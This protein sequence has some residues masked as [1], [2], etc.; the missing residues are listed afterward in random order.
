MMI[1]I[2]FH[3]L[4]N[5]DLEVGAIYE[6]GHHGTL[7]GEPIS[8]V[9]RGCGNQG[10]IRV[11]GQ[12]GA[13]KFVV[14]YSTFSDQDWPDRL[15]SEKAKLVYFGDNKKPGCELHETNAGGNVFFRE[16]F[17]NLHATPNGRASA[18]AIFLFSRH[19]TTAS[20]RSVIFRGLCVPGHPGYSEM[21]DLVAVWKSK[22]GGRYQN[23]RAVFS[24]LNVSVVKRA[25]IKDIQ[26]GNS[27][28]SAAPQAWIN[29]VEQGVYE[30]LASD[31]ANSPTSDGI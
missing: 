19:E 13:R 29:W 26:S 23:Y 31:P 9:L 16:L 20:R 14:L 25:W 2:D 27:K 22:D 10:G 24:V 4:E 3:D 7:A 21:D 30:L 17:W 12:F 8:K 11:S 6:G 15:D 1:T 5:S 28:T 18:P